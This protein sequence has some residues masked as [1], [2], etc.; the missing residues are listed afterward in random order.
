MSDTSGIFKAKYGDALQGLDWINKIEPEDRKLLIEIGLRATDYGRT[1]GRARAEK[2]I[3]DN[4]GHFARPDGTT[5]LDDV[6][7]GGFK[8]Q[9][10]RE[11][12][13]GVDFDPDEPMCQDDY[14]YFSS[15]GR[16][17]PAQSRGI[18]IYG[19]EVVARGSV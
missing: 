5:K 13:P 17:E 16:Y 8:E 15:T 7:L 19:F 9:V 18:N 12:E 4:K 11:P 1:G 6:N 10:G 2:A 14:E 3:R